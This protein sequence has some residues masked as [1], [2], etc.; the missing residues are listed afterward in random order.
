MEWTR[1]QVQANPTDDFWR[2]TGR[3]LAFM[4]GLADAQPKYASELH[5]LSRLEIIVLQAAGDLYD[6]MPAIDGPPRQVQWYELDYHE[7]IKKRH[8]RISCSC[9]WKM[10]DDKTDVYVSHATWSC[11]YIIDSHPLP[12]QIIMNHGPH[13]LTRG[14]YLLY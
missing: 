4:D 13:L 9:L 12:N 6:I 11:K 10:S 8:E 7:M 3:V 5:A 2:Q 14:T 1:D